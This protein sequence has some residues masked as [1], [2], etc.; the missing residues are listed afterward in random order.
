[1]TPQELAAAHAQDRA[2]RAELDRVL[3]A[4]DQPVP[5]SRRALAEENARLRE[6]KEAAEIAA[7]NASVDALKAENELM[8]AQLRQ[9]NNPSA[10][11]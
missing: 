11:Q 7:N 5:S 9:N 8:R 1:M 2:N 6:E 3:A 10:P 4:R